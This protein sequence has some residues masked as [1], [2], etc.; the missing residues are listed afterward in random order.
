MGPFPGWGSTISKLQCHYE[1]TFYFLP[2][3]PQ[4]YIV[5]S[6]TTSEGWKAEMTSE[7]PS[8]LETGTPRLGMSLLLI[9][10]REALAS[11]F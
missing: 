8:D 4:E 10:P 7:P 11:S 6:W 5:L 3:S 2:L 1:E 9:I